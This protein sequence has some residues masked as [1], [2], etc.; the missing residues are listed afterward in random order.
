MKS[1]EL[2]WYLLVEF[3]LS[4]KVLLQVRLEI[5]DSVLVEVID[6]G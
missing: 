5:A 4:L 6:L 3:Y 2:D 1:K